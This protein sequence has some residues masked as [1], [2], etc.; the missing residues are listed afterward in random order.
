MIM[1]ILDSIINFVQNNNIIDNKDN[2]ISSIKE[3]ENL[4]GLDKVKKTFYKQIKYYLLIKTGYID[5][6]DNILSPHVIFTGHSGVGKTT[7]AKLMIKIWKELDIYNI[8]NN[9]NSNR[10]KRKRENFINN[11]DTNILTNINDKINNIYKCYDILPR[12]KKNDKFKEIISKEIKEL[13]SIL[14]CYFFNSFNT[15]ENSTPSKINLSDMPQNLSFKCKNLGDKFITPNKW[16]NYHE[17]I[18]GSNLNDMNDIF[19]NDKKFVP[20]LPKYDYFASS[21]YLNNDLTKELVD[22]LSSLSDNF[23]NSENK[24]NDEI[25]FISRADIVGK[26]IGHTAKNV[27]D[28]FNKNKYIFIDEAYSLIEGGPNDFGKEAITEI[29]NI[30]STW[31]GILILSGYNDKMKDFL[32]SNEGLS[33]R[34]RWHFEIEKYNHIELFKIFSYQ[35]SKYKIIIDKSIPDNWFHDK[36]ENFG[37][38]G[39]STELLVEQCQIILTDKIWK[40]VCNGNRTLSISCTDNVITFELLNNAYNSYKN[41]IDNIRE[42]NILL[43]MYN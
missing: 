27:R 11:N 5:N 21:H 18:D 35:A 34:F 33:S 24:H 4:I 40:N 37:G 42:K 19:K 1:S 20:I 7:I 29:V 8:S 14:Q 32:R 6:K 3:F 38:L 26:Y 23:L 31:K 39:R 36:M 30:L 13:E 9:N 15:N 16:I 22:N 17:Y 28:I 41:L 43:S 12:S 25:I 10:K 2:F